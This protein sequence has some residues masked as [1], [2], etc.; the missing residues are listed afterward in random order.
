MKWKLSA[1]AAGVILLLLPSSGTRMAARQPPATGTAAYIVVRLDGLGGTSGGAN[2]VNNRGWVTGLASLAGDQTAHATLWLGGRTIDLKTLGGPNSA[3]SWPVKNDRGEIVGISETA[4]VD[5]LGETFSCAAFF[6]TPHTGHSC[7]GFLWRD[8]AMT[9]LD[10]L[11]G[12]NSYATAANDRGQIV[13][14]AENTV[15]DSTCKQPLQVLQFRA[16]IWGPRAGQI[17][18]LPPLPGDTTS[19]ATAINDRGQVVGIS[20]PCDRARGRFSAR[21]AVLWQ[22]G[23]ITDLG[24]FGGIAWNTPTAI[25]QRGDVAGFSDFP[26]DQG[27]GLNA[28]AFVW[29]GSGPIQDLHT[30]DDDPLSLAFGINN[31]RQVVG[32]SIG[33][34]GSRAF[35]WQDG[36]LAN[37]NDLVPPGSPFLIYANDINDAGEIVGQ[38]C[39]QCVGESFAVKLVPV[40]DDSDEAVGVSNRETPD[41]RHAVLSETVRRQ[42]E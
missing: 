33:A 31:L 29:I 3:V 19:A 6:G 21:R 9:K 34:G 1:R 42:L 15:H 36:V 32:Q 14:W 30:L 16:V 24:N 10:T 8:G 4:D 39:D 11:G 22:R 41:S 37:L 12:N 5:P 7:R 18:E 20:G 17:Q 28:H 27:G 40:R 23:T 38:A 25:N 13:G 2:S 26:G 35:L